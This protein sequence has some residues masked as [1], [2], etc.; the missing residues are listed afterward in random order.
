MSDD[1]DIPREALGAYLDGELPAAERADVER[2]LGEDAGA[3][4]Y[5]EELRALRRTLRRAPEIDFS[6]DRTGELLERIADAEPATRVRPVPTS[7]SLWERLSD[8]FAELGPWRPAL[9]FG[10]AAAAG[11]ALWSY[12]GAPA[13]SDEA[14]FAALAPDLAL[15][16]DYEVLEDL[17]ALE[18][19][20]VILELPERRG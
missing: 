18:D 6:R 16:E 3:R 4:A 2:L 5:L 19:F 17:D 7:H 10:L 13:P 11:V 9:A 1:R 12:W 8:W 15:Y 14:R 20:G